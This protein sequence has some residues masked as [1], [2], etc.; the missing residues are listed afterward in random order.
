MCRPLIK[1]DTCIKFNQRGTIINQDQV[2]Y[3]DVM[4]NFIKIG[5]KQT[6]YAYKLKRNSNL[7]PIDKESSDLQAY[8]HG[9]DP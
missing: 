7:K 8:M 3:F 2:T 9:Q 4:L 1:P 5:S 6:I